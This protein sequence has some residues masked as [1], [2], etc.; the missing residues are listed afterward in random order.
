MCSKWDRIF[1]FKAIVLYATE[2]TVHIVLHIWTWFNTKMFYWIR[3]FRWAEKIVI[4]LPKIGFPVLVRQHSSIELTH[5]LLFVKCHC[6]LSTVA[7]NKI[8][9]ELKIH[10]KIEHILNKGINHWSFV[11]IL[12]VIPW[13]HVKSSCT[14]WTV[15]VPSS[16]CFYHDLYNVA[17]ERGGFI[18]SVRLQFNGI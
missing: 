10:C 1:T 17:N 3:K 9:C 7:T 4:R 13:P 18:Y 14:F 5:G 6:N 11:T 15:L 2:S 8:S 12:L 16:M